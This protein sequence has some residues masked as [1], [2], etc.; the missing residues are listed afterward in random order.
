M[1]ISLGGLVITILVVAVFV[2]G[3]KVKKNSE[4]LQELE[5]SLNKE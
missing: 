4:Q 2:I 1:S 5:E 3:A